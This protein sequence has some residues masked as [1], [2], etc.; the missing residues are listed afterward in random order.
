MLKIVYNVCPNT[1]SSID[2][3]PHIGA[4]EMLEYHGTRQTVAKW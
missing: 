3:L 1:R 2:E 4:H